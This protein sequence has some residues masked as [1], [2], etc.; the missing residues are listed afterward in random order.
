MAAKSR[1]G[2]GRPRHDNVLTQAEWR[3]LHA[4]QH[5]LGNREIAE[6]SGIS[7]DAVKY[8]VRN[9][10]AKLGVRSRRELLHWFAPP[11]SSP[12][13]RRETEMSSEFRLGPIGQISRTVRNIKEAEAWYG[14]VLGLPHLF[15]YG[16]LAFFDCGGTRLYLDEKDEAPAAESI[17]YLLV[18]DIEAAHRA[19]AARGVQFRNAPHLIFRH[20]DGTEEWMAFFDDPEGRPL[21]LMARARPAQ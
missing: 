9:V 20:P 18:E 16:K 10:V 17:L 1:R 6:R 11:K 2:R 14:G 19:L 7:A 21:A 15:S 3:T 4:L 13:K 8:H 12:L 5:G